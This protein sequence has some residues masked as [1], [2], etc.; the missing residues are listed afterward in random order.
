MPSARFAP[1]RPAPVPPPPVAAPAGD[2]GGQV[3][4]PPGAVSSAALATALARFPPADLA[5]L[6]ARA[7]LQR[8]DTK[9]LVP[10]ALLPALLGELPAHYAVLGAPGALGSPYRTL[11]FDTPELRC[12]HD[13]RRGRRLRHKLRIR[14][15]DDRRL[16]YLEIKSR[17]SSALTDKARL[18]LPYD[19]GH[20]D[21]RCAA[22]IAARCQ[23]DAAQL[24]P[25]LW[26][27][28]RRLTL[29]GLHRE[30]RCTLDFSLSVADVDHTRT[31][32][33]LDGL[34]FLEVKQP[35]P[36]PAS[37]M[38]RALRALQQRPRSLSKYLVAVCE[39]H[40]EERANQ[41]RPTLRA[42]RTL[43]ATSGSVAA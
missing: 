29:I 14:T 42:V 38:L 3:P 30:E 4:L 6:Q 11:Y 37:P 20:L 35:E 25:Q 26:I 28:Y 13:H 10:I 1:P 33:A 2:A 17:R 40:P 7:L 23:L 24:R 18:E 5:L 15:Y 21:E 43:R 12:F 39:L 34:A 19:Q 22:L 9:F 16:T 41:L 36:D 32:A 31:T 27:D 8:S